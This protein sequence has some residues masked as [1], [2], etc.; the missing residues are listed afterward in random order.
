MMRPLRILAAAAV[1]AAASAPALGAGGAG[2]RMEPAQVDRLDAA[3]LQRGA[4][5]FVNYCLGCHSA[6]FVRYNTLAQ[7]GLTEAQVRDNLILGDQK[8]GDVMTIA[9]DPADAKRWFGVTPPDLSVIARVRGT[10][11]LYNYFLAFYRDETSPSGWNNLVFP[12]VGMPHVLWQVAGTQRLVRTEFPDAHRAQEAVL[13]AR[14]LS[15]TEPAAGGKFAVLTLAP[16]AQGQLSPAEY[17]Q[18]VGDLVNYLNWMGE[19]VR[20]L[21]IQI[22]IG[23]LLFLGVLFVLVYAL[24]REYWK[25]L[26]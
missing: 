22:G 15:R 18:F 1:L 19:P 9:M 21:R 23:V 10:D 4:R 2:L 12:N 26:H 5:N 11:W 13:A 6:R 20:N 17:Q 14:G 8:L 25:E 16:D 24:K 7:L 3:S